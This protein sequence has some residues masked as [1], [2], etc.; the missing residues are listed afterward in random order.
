MGAFQLI[1]SKR[2]AV[3]TAPVV[4]YEKLLM[5]KLQFLLL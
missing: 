2:Y 4:D 3:I 1:S 5:P